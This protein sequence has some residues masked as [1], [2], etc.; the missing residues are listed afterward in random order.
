MV[1]WLIHHNLMNIYP[2]A[3]KKSSLAT[4]A[5]RYG[6]WACILQ[7]NVNSEAHILQDILYNM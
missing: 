5:T 3:V 4:F 6:R 1:R 2:F 7:E